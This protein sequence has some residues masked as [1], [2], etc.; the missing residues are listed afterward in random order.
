MIVPNIG[1][2]SLELLFMLYFVMEDL[3]EEVIELLRQTW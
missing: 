2:E 3:L 1:G